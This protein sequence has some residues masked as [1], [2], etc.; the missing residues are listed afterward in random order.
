[1]GPGEAATSQLPSGLGR[2]PLLLPGAPEKACSGRQTCC[3]PFFCAVWQSPWSLWHGSVTDW[4]EGEVPLGLTGRGPQRPAPGRCTLALQITPRL[5]LESQGR[6]G[7]FSSNFSWSC[8]VLAWSSGHTKGAGGRGPSSLVR[9]FLRGSSAA[10]QLGSG[11]GSESARSTGRSSREPWG[12]ALCCSL[13]ER[14]HPG[15]WAIGVSGDLAHL[16]PSR[17][18]LAQS[19]TPLFPCGTLQG[20]L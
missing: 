1:M 8:A 13:V 10:E 14:L 6:P 18:Q 19:W 16:S 4:P 7:G 2:C 20:F 5:C 17:P 11:W 15:W 3:L 12:P 9:V